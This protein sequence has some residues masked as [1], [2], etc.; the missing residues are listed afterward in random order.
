[1]SNP[2]AE[3]FSSTEQQYGLPEGY[4]ERT[5]RV[6]SSFNPSAKNPNSSAGGLFQFIDGTA[7]QYGLADRY[8]P[9]QATDAAA[10]L[11]RD[12]AAIL[13]RTLGREPTAGELYL[14]HQQGA[15]GA[16]KLLSNPDAPAEAIVGPAAARLNGGRGLT[17]GELAQKWTAKID[18]PQP[19]SQGGN[20]ALAYA[21][22]RGRD[23]RA[24]MPAPDANVAMGQM[25]MP[26]QAPPD[27]TT[28][29][30]AGIRE[31]LLYEAGAAPQQQAPAQG[32]GG[33]M[34]GIAQAIGGLG[35]LGGI[36]IPGGGGGSAT[37]GLPQPSLNPFA[38][39][40][41]ARENEQIMQKYR[42]QQALVQELVKRGIPAEEAVNLIGN[43]AALNMRLSTIG[44]QKSQAATQQAVQQLSGNPGQPQD[45]SAA[46]AGPARVSVMN[47]P[48][49]QGTTVTTRARMTQILN[50]LGNENVAK[51]VREAAEKEYQALLENSKMTNEQKTHAQ[52]LADGSFK[53]G[54]YD[55]EVGLKQAGRPQ[56]NVSLDARAETA[57]SKGRGEGLAKRWNDIADDGVKANEDAITFQR[58]ADVLG[59]V[60]TGK[61]TETLEKIRQFTGIALDPNTDNVQALNAMINYIAPRLRVP[62]SGAQSD[63][64]LGNF[65]QSIPSLAGTPG[66]NKIILDTMSGIVDYRKQRAAI[67]A[68]WQNGDISAKEAQKRADAI[69]LPF[70]KPEKPESG[71]AGGSSP[72]GAVTPKVGD[73]ATN[74]TTGEKRRFDGN[75]WV[76]FK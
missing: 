69:P 57:E 27:A 34:G 59:T 41:A 73:T 75:G 44:Q 15:G 31:L 19:A 33:I 67:A 7:K 8:D 62:G 64:E 53:G 72:S 56:T 3:L 28:Q 51:G 52:A 14:A 46:P 71:N 13:K 47:D 50:V 55:Y 12:N 43:E 74:P 21:A 1:M 2:F 10:R 5:A 42:G 4:L 40:A 60:S 63:R 9:A 48:V 26:R 18:G 54:I 23:P 35:G 20:P 68:E 32:G 45:S 58:F 22:T 39:G 76:P 38:F 65:L 70:K 6:E 61:T 36:R 66:G 16:V 49:L 25:P 29:D 17:A 37:P 24:N 11:A 30:N